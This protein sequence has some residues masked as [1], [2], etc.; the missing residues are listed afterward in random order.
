MAEVLLEH[1]PLVR[2]RLVQSGESLGSLAARLE[3]LY[4]AGSREWPDIPLS[5]EGFVRALASHLEGDGPVVPDTFHSSDFFIAA[6]CAEGVPGAVT[7]LERAFLS[8]IPSY[9]AKVC[10][11]SD[12]VKPEDVAQTI[13]E[14]VVVPAGPRP[15]RI[16]EYSGKGPLGGWLRVLS[17]RVALNSKR[18]KDRFVSELAAPNVRSEVD[19]ELDLFR[20]E[21]KDE[22]KAALEAAFSTLDEEQRSLLRLHASGAHRGEDIARMLGVDRS[23]AVRR[24]ARARAQILETTKDLMMKKLGVSASEFDSIARAVYSQIELSLSRLLAPRS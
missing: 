23:T 15:P 6:A 16:A 17:V 22:L 14:H 11:P 13:A 9:I 24:L 2:S 10:K 8:R 3:D 5:E 12:R 18:A 7:A 4:R 19:P 21:Y 20:I 1:N